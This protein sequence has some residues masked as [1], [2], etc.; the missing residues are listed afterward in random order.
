MNFRDIDTWDV[1]CPHCDEGVEDILEG[2]DLD[3]FLSSNDMLSMENGDVKVVSCPNC[4][5]SI[6]VK[7]YL[8]ISFETVGGEK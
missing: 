8:K 2:E 3:N 1:Y 4:G 7:A 6:K 5:K